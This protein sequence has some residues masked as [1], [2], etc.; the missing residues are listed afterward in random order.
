L[1]VYSTGAAGIATCS[2]FQRKMSLNEDP[3]SNAR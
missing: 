1:I 2:L 3:V